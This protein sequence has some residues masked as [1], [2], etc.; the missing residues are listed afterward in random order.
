MGVTSY[1]LESSIA[2]EFALRK[3]IEQRPGDAEAQNLY[4]LVAEQHARYHDAER[5]F[6]AAEA[7]LT[8]TLVNSHHPHLHSFIFLW[9]FL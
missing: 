1:R 9:L 8:S 5:S 2:A 7:V 3:V 4:G 6:A